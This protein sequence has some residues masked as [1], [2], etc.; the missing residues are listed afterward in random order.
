M[1]KD[2]DLLERAAEI[3][4][5]IRDQHPDARVELD[6]RSPLE[7]LVATM[8]AAQ[9]TDKRVNLV[10]P[11]L[12]RTYRDAAAFAAASLDELE[13]AVHSTGFF[14]QKSRSLKACCTQLVERHGGQVPQT[15]PELTALTGVGRKT[16]N[17][18]L[19]AGFGL[20]G[21]AV[22][23]HCKRLSNRL[24]L[25]A[26]ADPVKIEKCLGQLYVPS[27]WAEVSRLFVWHGRHTCKARTP[28]CGR[29]S[30]VELCPWQRDNGILAS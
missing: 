30:L 27:Q 16:A 18:V 5:R 22:D 17:V 11:G 23:T 20:P 7:L 4:S 14:R 10:T 8:L 29:C 2:T 19:S 1:S 28:E 25:V 6:F 9:S 15:L 13:V 12:F 21:I 24:G 26:E 3:L